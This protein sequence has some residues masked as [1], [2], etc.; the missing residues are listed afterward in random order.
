MT[1][2]AS[3]DGRHMPAG[4]S[5]QAALEVQ[6]DLETA[7]LEGLP[8]APSSSSEEP[9]SWDFADIQEPVGAPA[10]EVSAPERPANGIDIDLETALV[11]GLSEVGR[12]PTRESV[13]IRLPDET[14]PSEGRDDPGP[15]ATP[16][17]PERREP[18]PESVLDFENILV[19]ASSDDPSASLIE[20]GPVDLADI[21]P[22]A[23]PPAG[24]GPG[25]NGAVSGA[26]DE[27]PGAL[28]DDPPP[29]RSDD[30]ELSNPTDDR[31]F[32]VAVPEPGPDAPVPGDA[33]PTGIDTDPEDAAGERTRE[34]PVAA[35]AFAADPETEDILRQGL[36][37]FEGP[38]PDCDDPQVWPGGLRAAVAA[39]ADGH[40]SGLVIVDVDGISYP[41]GAIHEL[42]EVCEV[43]T[44]VIAV[45]SNDTARFSRE[46]LLAGVGEYLVKPL[47]VEAVR[48]ATGRVF[49]A[50]GDTLATGCVAGFAG[51]GGS[52]ATTLAVAAALHAAETG[53]YVSVLDLNRTVPVA[54]LSLDVHPAAGLEQL[55]EVAGE[56]PPDAKMLNGVRAR[57]SERV[58]VYAYR[59][60]PVLPATPGIPAL[61]WLVGELRNRSQLVLIDG[62]DDPWTQFALLSEVDVPVL[63]AEPTARGTAR[64][65]RML[66]LLEGYPPAVTVRNHTRPFRT[67]AG[68]R[69]LIDAEMETAPDIV[70]PHLPSLPEIADRGWPGDRL[71]RR[72]RK[73]V[74]GLLDRIVASARV[75]GLAS[76]ESRREAA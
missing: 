56:A 27:V 45:G 53:R 41:S 57:R 30:G 51:T 39:L 48:D 52:G 71:P 29:T 26:A 1:F 64:A 73:P 50:R 23:P 63:V 15:P 28:P 19:E 11:A 68:A 60:A 6:P 24:T 70:V 74:A 18:A 5:I 8:E 62:I 69:S 35:L 33:I 43:G 46:I 14:D 2:D 17:V 37:H 4:N 3:A 7:L 54:A 61:A 58:S 36:L 12:K 76:V 59:W 31:E 38:T 22:P 55:L 13:E 25:T 34:G 20:L 49:A 66:Q 75:A 16:A 10:R 42:A 72:L 44:A 32:A 21:S 40:S 47:T 67:D 9:G 65:A